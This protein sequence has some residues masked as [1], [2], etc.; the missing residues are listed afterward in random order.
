MT[1]ARG[2]ARETIKNR[3]RFLDKLDLS[4]ENLTAPALGHGNRV[5][6]VTFED[7][8]RGAFNLEEAFP[9]TDGLV[10]T[11]PGLILAVTTADCLPVFV[12]DDAQ[13]VVGITHTGW[14]G[15][16]GGVLENLID[17]VISCSTTPPSELSAL[18]GVGIGAC[19]YT[20]EADRVAAFKPLPRGL[21]SYVDAG[22]THLDLKRIAVMKLA[23]AG[24]EAEKIEVVPEC[25][26]CGE[27]YPSYR[28]MGEDF[29]PDLALITIG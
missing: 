2:S 6:R 17:T 12:W 29:A 21:I 7:R 9:A 19:C 18:I 27:G 3:K 8:G 23:A 22:G 25:S 14:K 28:R 1:Y 15:L 13:S 16:A 11:A 24:L 20:V 26:A 10:T 5:R 4:L